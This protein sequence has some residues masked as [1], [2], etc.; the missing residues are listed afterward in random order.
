MLKMNGVIELLIDEN[1]YLRDHISSKNRL[2]L[3]LGAKW[4]DMCL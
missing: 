1:K 2:V 4:S 3:S